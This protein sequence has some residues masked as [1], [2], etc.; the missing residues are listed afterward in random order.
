[1]ADSSTT[2]Q[3][4]EQELQEILSKPAGPKDD[5][6]LKDK[7]QAITQLAT[8]YRTNQDATSL[9]Q[10]VHSSRPLMEHLAKAKTAKLIRT[11]LDDF[12]AIPNASK[13]QIQ[14]TKDNIEWAKA[15]KR[16]FLKQSLETRLIALYIDTLA[17]KDA[18]ALINSLLREL[19]KL[20]DKMVLTEVHLLESRV[21]HALSNMPKAKVCFRAL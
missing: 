6:L 12:S 8:L 3:R 18:L 5:Q 15:E 20:D 17:Y 2:P 19:K 4:S 14:V 13:L 7:E 10:L 11:L 9:A 16:I 1:M 21:H